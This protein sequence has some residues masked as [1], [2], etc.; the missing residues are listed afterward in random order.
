MAT[1]KDFYNVARQWADTG[2]G[3]DNGYGYQCIGLI[4]GLNR[5]IGAG[6]TTYVRNDAA[7]NMYYDY[8]SGAYHTTGWH[9]VAGYPKNDAESKKV[10]NTLPNGAI[11]FWESSYQPYGHVAIKIA[12]W[13]APNGDVVQQN[14]AEPWRPAHYANMGAFTESGGQGFIGAI[15]SDDDGWGGHTQGSGGTTTPKEPSSGS[16]AKEDIK[17]KF[18]EIVNDFLDQMKKLFN[19]NVYN[20]SQQYMFNKVVKLTKGANLWRLKLS[21]EALDELR[22]V[23]KEAIKKASNEAIN[24]TQPEQAGKVPST[25]KPSG[26]TGAEGTEDEK[27]DIICRIIKQYCPNANPF[28]IAGMLGNFAAESGIDPTNFESKAYWDG[29]TAGPSWQEL[30][31]VENLFDTW[32]DFQA[33]YGIPLNEGAYLAGGAHWLGLGLGQWTGPRAKALVD[34]CKERGLEWYTCKGQ[35]EFAFNGDGA[36]IGILKSCLVN[37]EYVEEGVQNFYKYWERAN[38]GSSVPHRN[39]EAKRLFPKV[40]AKWDSL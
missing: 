7:K 24:S 10:W 38:V 6:L 4:D 22:N 2:N 30:P 9:T 3:Y 20:G 29:K 34:F 21:D 13:G 35:M 32:A 39:S 40:K 31:T 11:V 1:C 15:V 16:T 26:V 36:N 28:G 14:G 8:A 12:D 27:I 37:S 23:L 17:K 18:D 33:L 5:A 25:S 19:Q